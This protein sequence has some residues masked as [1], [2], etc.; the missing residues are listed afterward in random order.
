M[1]VVCNMYWHSGGIRSID[2][3]PEAEG[4]LI[5]NNV[6]LRRLT[7]WVLIHLLLTLT[8]ICLISYRSS[9]SIVSSIALFMPKTEPVL[10][11]LTIIRYLLIKA[12]NRSTAVSFL[13]QPQRVKV[14]LWDSLGWECKN[15]F[16]S[17]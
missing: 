5:T 7:H 17:C 3:E 15:Y 16:V 4:N 14:F 1:E 9:V 12:Q 11:H 2:I 13:G 8:P 6:R 10:N